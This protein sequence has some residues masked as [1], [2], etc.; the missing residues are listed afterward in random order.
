MFVTGSGKRIGSD[1]LYFWQD[2][3]TFVDDG[4]NIEPFN[5]EKENKEGF[6]DETGNYVEYVNEKQIKVLV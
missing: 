2:N 6:F 5:L 1:E 3:D 4:V